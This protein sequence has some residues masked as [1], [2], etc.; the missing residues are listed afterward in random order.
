[1]TMPLRWMKPVT[2]RSP[3]HPGLSSRHLLPGPN[4][5]AVRCG[6]ASLARHRRALTRMG[7]GDKPRDD[8]VVWSRL[9]YSSATSPTGRTSARSAVKQRSEEHTSELQSLMRISYAVFCLKK[10]HTVQYPIR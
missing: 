7:P 3:G 4:A 1:M 8:S 9:A 6:D 5:L 2:R 10:K